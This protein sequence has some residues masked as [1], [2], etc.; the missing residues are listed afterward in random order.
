M[1]LPCAYP[2]LMLL[3]TLL[4]QVSVLQGVMQPGADLAPEAE[5]RRTGDAPRLRCQPPS[6]AEAALVSWR[7]CNNLPTGCGVIFRQR[8][9]RHESSAASEPF[10]VTIITTQVIIA[11]QMVLEEFIYK[12]DVHLLQGYRHG[13]YVAAGSPSPL[14]LGEGVVMHPGLLC[15]PEAPFG[16][17]WVEGEQG[18]WRWR[19]GF[20]EEL[21]ACHASLPTSCGCPVPLDPAWWA[22]IEQLGAWGRVQRACS[23]LQLLPCH[24]PP[25]G[26]DQLLAA[27]TNPP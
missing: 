14:V 23:A 18:R 17:D 10:Q 25:K 9:P 5:G 21:G 8:D 16:P 6:S 15:T 24:L 26:G 13:G 3:S 19:F 12:H 4:P 20:P 22:K 7:G 2:S 11:I 1:S 27:G